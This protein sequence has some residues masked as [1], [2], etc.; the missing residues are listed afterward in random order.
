MPTVD[1]I[2]CK[3][4]FV[5][6]AAQLLEL[7][8]GTL[9]LYEEAVEAN[10]IESPNSK[11]ATGIYRKINKFT[12]G[13]LINNSKHKMKSVEELDGLLSSALD[14]RNRLSHSFYSEHNFRLRAESDEGRII[15]LHDLER[16]HEIILDAYR[17]VMLTSGIDLENP[18][19]IPKEY[20][21][22]EAL[23]HVKI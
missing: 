14:E 18:E 11:I 9:L 5:A 10:L 6:E 15:M 2:Y 3:F 19:S 7:E 12:L 16:M 21:E 13:R 1:D 20:Q 4:G 23:G 17:A 22:I 8:L